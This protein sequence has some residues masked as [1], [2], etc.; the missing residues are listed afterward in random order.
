MTSRTPRATIASRI[1]EPEAG[2]APARLGH[3]HRALERRG[4][5]TTVLTTRAPTARTS[6]GSVRRWPVL[7]D[8]SGTVRGYLQY[9]SFDVPLFFRL[10]FGRRT[11]VVVVEPPPTSGF[12]ALLATRIRRTPYVYFSADV[13]SSALAAIRVNPLVAKLVRGVERTVARSASRVLAVSE[14][15]RDELVELGVPAASI[16][17]VGTGIDTERYTPE[18]GRVESDAP[19]FVYAGT[20]SEIQGAGVFLEAFRRIA[21]EHPGV[22]LEMLG[23]GVERHTLERDAAALAERIRFHG[24]VSPEEVSRWTRGAVAGLASVRPERGYDFAYSTKALMTAACGTPV[25]FAGAGPVAALVREHSLGWAVPWDPDAVAGAL[26]DALR[27]P[28][29]LPEDAVRWVVDHHSLGAVAERGVDAILQAV[30]DAD[31]G[32]RSR[33]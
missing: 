14:G 2:A 17:V 27:R 20:M 1:F 26:R 4:I 23:D 11:D 18:G 31:G 30:E 33:G 12:A 13:T 22:K 7:R 5:R 21:A 6:S 3:L 28:A 8:R 24:F 19:Y 32:P 15:V 16:T 29:R 9:A 10:L 25:V